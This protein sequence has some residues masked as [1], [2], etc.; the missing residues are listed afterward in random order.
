MISMGDSIIPVIV[1]GF[2]AWF[3]H[4]DP[5]IGISI[6][7]VGDPEIHNVLVYW[8]QDMAWHRHTYLV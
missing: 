3:G 7:G 4:E 8:L 5:G 1:G 2:W 6:A